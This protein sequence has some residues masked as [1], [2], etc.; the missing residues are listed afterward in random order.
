MT[1]IS[2]SSSRF[3]LI[4]NGTGTGI[5]LEKIELMAKL[6]IKDE[7]NGTTMFPSELNLADK[8]QENLC[9]MYGFGLPSS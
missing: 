9:S 1:P 4:P 5:T 2:P 7:N 3:E 6:K 8:F